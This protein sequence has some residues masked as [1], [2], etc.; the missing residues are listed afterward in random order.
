MRLPAK[1]SPYQQ[2]WRTPWF[3][4]WQPIM[5][6]VLGTV[7]WYV[8]LV[9]IVAVAAAIELAVSGHTF[10]NTLGSGVGSS[11]SS[12]TPGLFLA[13]NVA[14]AV[15]LPI[16]VVLQRWFFGLRS[17]WLLSVTGKV[18]RGWIPICIAIVVPIW[19]VSYA[20]ELVFSGASELEGLAW[21]EQSLVLI[22]GILLTTPL[23]AAAEEYLCRGFI[24]RAVGSYFNNPKVA[25]W[26]GTVVSTAVFT[27]MHDAED[28]WLNL[29]YIAFGV[30][31]C[32]VTW[33]TGSLIPGIVIH[34]VNNLI[35]EATMP[36]SDISGLFERSS[37]A[38]DWTVL[39]QV[40]ALLI[41]GALI[42]WVAGR[43]G[44]ETETPA[45]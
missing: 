32:W 38:G 30:I 7:F 44:L 43:C 18:R 35:A 31:L 40:A 45:I 27:Y 34:I 14:L 22:I 23:Q 21:S 10:I 16:A 39:I 12:T 3:K 15:I 28:A 24:F 8:L 4:W 5:A 2:V 1:P 19:I 17:G 37:G 29:S 36:F 42:I 13:N 41:A 25:F 9:I 26:A 6:S 33:K 20:A 11:G